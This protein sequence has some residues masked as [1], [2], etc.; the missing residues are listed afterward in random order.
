MITLEV[1]HVIKILF[2][3][4]DIRKLGH[5]SFLNEILPDF[6]FLPLQIRH[7]TEF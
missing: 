5:F 3:K 2:K 7:Y 4:T 6:W 1:Q